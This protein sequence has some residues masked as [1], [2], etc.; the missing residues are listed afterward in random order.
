MGLTTPN[1]LI[2]INNLAT[3]LQ[4]EGRYAE[5]EPLYRRALAAFQ[6]SL[7]KDDPRILDCINNL[8]SLLEQSGRIEEAL[9]TQLDALARRRRP[10]QSQV[11]PRLAVDINNLGLAYRKLGQFGKAESLAREALELDRRHSPDAPIIP[12]RLN[13]LASILLLSGAMQEAR[14]ILAEAWAREQGEAELTSSRIAFM[15]EVAALLDNEPAGLYIDQLK[16]L[17]AV[18]P[19]PDHANVV[20]TWDIDHFI[21]YLRPK[22]T[23]EQTQFLSAVTA[24][25]NDRAKLPALDTFAQW[26]SQSAVP[27][28]TPWPVSTKVITQSV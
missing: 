21:S 14:G 25:M 24:A 9:D 26:N 15:R 4:R 1:A 3:L 6:S 7:G 17:L 13:N 22:L 23:E 20:K 16:T 27:L 8:A 28:N 18:D 12:H 10:D 2:T 11:D 5:A 19:L